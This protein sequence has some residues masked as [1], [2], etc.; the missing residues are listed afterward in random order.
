MSDKEKK[1][2]EVAFFKGYVTA[3]IKSGWVCGD[4]GNT[5]EANVKN[6]PNDMLDSAKVDLARAVH[7]EQVK[8]SP[9]K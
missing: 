8:K 1:I 5:Y 7:N 2:D 9:K 6:C 3:L 4:C